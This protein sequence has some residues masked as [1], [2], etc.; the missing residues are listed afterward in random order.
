ML[1]DTFK[2][3]ESQIWAKGLMYSMTLTQNDKNFPAYVVDSSRKGNHSR[4]IN[5]SCDPNLTTYKIIKDDRNI[6]R[7]CPVL[8]A[9]KDIE[10]GTELTFNYKIEVQ[11]QDYDASNENASS[12]GNADEQEKEDEFG[13]I[14][15]VNEKQIEY[16]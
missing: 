14:F 15:T 3:A 6:N 2:L 7:P 8:F 1:E 4:L 10:P 5:H 11:N 13:P 12:E 16:Y 9:N